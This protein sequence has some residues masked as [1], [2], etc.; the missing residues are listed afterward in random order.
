MQFNLGSYTKF[1]SDVIH[2]NLLSVNKGDMYLK[3]FLELF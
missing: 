3:Q 1:V 2:F